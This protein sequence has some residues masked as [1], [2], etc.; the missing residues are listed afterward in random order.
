MWRLGESFVDVL[1]ILQHRFDGVPPAI[2][3]KLI[4][5]G[6]S[7]VSA[8]DPGTVPD[9]L[10]THQHHVVVAVQTQFMHLLDVPGLFALVPQAA[11]GAAPVDGLPEVD[12]ALQGLAVGS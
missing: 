3:V 8:G 4:E 10:H 5:A 7:T 2:A 6:M 12:C 1:R 11:Q 9:L